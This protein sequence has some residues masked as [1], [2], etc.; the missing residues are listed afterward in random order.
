MTE[1]E[2]Y[3]LMERMVIMP[4][5]PP[6]MD[7][8]SAIYEAVGSGDKELSG[9]AAALACARL[10]WL[11][12][13]MTAGER[14]R[15]A[16]MDAAA[17]G[18]DGPAPEG[19]EGEKAGR[20]ADASEASSMGDRVTM[21][22]F[23]VTEADSHLIHIAAE[24]GGKR[25]WDAAVCL[26][27][28][29]CSGTIEWQMK[30]SFGLA[31][32]PRLYRGMDAPSGRLE[33]ENRQD[34]W[35][36][37]MVVILERLHGFDPEKGSV[38]TYMKP[39]LLNL[40]KTSYDQVTRG[41]DRTTGYG[42]DLSR[43]YSRA[44]ARLAEQGYEDP[45]IVLITDAMQSLNKG[46]EAITVRKV[47]SFL[48]KRAA[49]VP[50]EG[51]ESVMPVGTTPE[52]DLLER[53]R[54]SVFDVFRDSLPGLERDIYDIAVS[55]YDGKAVPSNDALLSRDRDALP[56]DAADEEIKEA[57]KE[58]RGKVRDFQTK[59]TMK[60]PDSAYVPPVDTQDRSGGFDI[61]EF[62]EMNERYSLPD[63]TV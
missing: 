13:Q 5:E 2:R 23:G 16:C 58:L 1:A 35:N 38:V 20:K 25:G 44:M 30:K 11:T 36:E 49:L 3:G 19:E 12:E 26:T 33:D 37:C 54:S 17:A 24:H 53:E 42:A 45:S 59:G 6:A 56:P 63:R 4:D 7:A 41:G 10:E 47:E 43:L 62:F 40:F 27:Y 34:L 21:E 32:K 31:G 50:I 18:A 14:E 60:T 9:A 46:G 28:E 39:W 22:K 52:E 8:V 15:A 51:T 61:D 55:R 29:L 48:Q 57:A